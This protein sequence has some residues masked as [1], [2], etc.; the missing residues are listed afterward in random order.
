MARRVGITAPSI[1]AHFSDRDA[2][3]H[4]V[5]V[6]AFA[7]MAAGLRD[8]TDSVSDPVERLHAGGAAYLRLA[9]EQPERYRMLFGRRPTADPDTLRHAES[10]ETIV[11]AEAFGWLVD[12][13]RQCVEA[14]RSTTPSPLDSAVQIWVALHGFATLRT[15]GNDFPW[16]DPDTMVDALIGRL[17]YI[18]RPPARR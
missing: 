2:I 8:A 12:A 7:A 4:A 6:D 3:L 16:P 13:I 11:G 5:L 18:E 17:A 14:D 1:Y 15:S 10:A 9:A